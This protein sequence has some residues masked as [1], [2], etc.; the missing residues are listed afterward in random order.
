MSLITRCPACQTLFKVVPDQLRVSDGWVRCGQ[1]DEV[2]E[3][4]LHL[5]QDP[6]GQAPISDPAQKP[7]VSPG[8]TD[9]AAHEP[10]T[11]DIDLDLNLSLGPYEEA[12]PE[13]EQ[14][15][16]PTSSLTATETVWES[17]PVPPP[18]AQ[19][20]IAAEARPPDFSQSIL[21]ATRQPE[22]DPVAPV[23][24]EAAV[25]PAISFL[26][27]RTISKPAHTP[28][29][30]G[31]L[32]LSGLLL[33]LSLAIQIGLHERDRIAALAPDVKPWLEALCRPF[34]CT[35]SPLRQIE[36]MVIDSASFTKM[37]EGLY[38]LSF[39]LLNSAPY[40]LAMPAVELTLTDSLDRPV[41]RR[42][43]LPSELDLNAGTLAA[44]AEWTTALG[45]QVKPG[46]GADRVAGYRLYVFYP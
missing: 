7:L 6:V 12:I 26:Q 16:E 8:A 40:P 15:P 28:V 46:G 32:L 25:P 42:V 36:A 29:Q 5:V 23:E 13:P 44:R 17:E 27:A 3:A 24:T 39:V 11:S 38:R 10:A 14:S 43:F 2:F 30:R 20:V 37:G 34:A 9:G 4:P 21:L 35:L 19:E 1:C 33:L 41:L 22:Q 31:V 18:D 45:L